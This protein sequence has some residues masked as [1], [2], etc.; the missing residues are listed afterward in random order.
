MYQDGQ[1]MAAN[2]KV[3]DRVCRMEHGL[4]L[5]GSCGLVARRRRRSHSQAVVLKL[6]LLLQQNTARA[7][8]RK[9]KDISKCLESP[10]QDLNTT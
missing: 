6:L 7:G 1:K 10:A 8:R 3:T 4:F 9:K 5:R 2:S